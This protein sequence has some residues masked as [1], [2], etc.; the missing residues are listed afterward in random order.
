MS[1]DRLFVAS[2]VVP[3]AAPPIRCGGVLVRDGVIRGVGRA[4]DLA[5][6]R[7]HLDEVDLGKSILLPG[8][9]NSH[10]HLELSH[11]NAEASRGLPL[12]EWIPALG[13]QLQRDKPDFA[14]RTARATAAGAMESLRCGVTC[15]GDISQQ[16]TV[17]RPVLRDGPLRVVSF[18]EALGLA[19]LRPRFEEQRARA[20]DLSDESPFL[21]CGISPHAPYTVDEPGM[22]QCVCDAIDARRPIAVHLSETRE[23]SEFTRQLA[24]PFRSLWERIGSWTDDVPCPGVTPIELAERSGLLSA[25]ALLAHVNHVADAELELLSQRPSS[26][27][28]CPRTHA[29]FGHP[30]HR[31]REMLDRGITVAIGTDS[32]ASNPD[33]D[34]LQEVRVVGRLAP[35]LPPLALLR[36][37]TVNAARALAQP[38]RC[39]AL[40]PG[41]EADFAVFPLEGSD[42]LNTL[43]REPLECRSTWVD[44]RSVFA[45]G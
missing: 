25:G 43:L 41:R 6:H 19:R 35:D 39:G 23:E 32:R 44:G 3:I 16:V 45:R 40:T 15:V 26:V 28:Y 37:V 10:V 8:L 18:G 38:A 31:W 29:Y 27:V 36:L 1:R 22:R 21:R 20:L 17:T 11:C 5:R 14:D 42:P 4:A 7:R 24:G 34:L 30:P 12:V 2:L 9:V 33:L 13:Q